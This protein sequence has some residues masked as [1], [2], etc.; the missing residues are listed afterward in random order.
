MLVSRKI[1][2]SKRLWTCLVFGALCSLLALDFLHLLPRSH[3][4]GLHGSTPGKPGKVI[5][6]ISHSGNRTQIA[7]FWVS[8]ES[9][10]REAKPQ[11]SGIK[12]NRFC[13]VDGQLH[14]QWFESLVF[15]ACNI[16]DMTYRPGEHEKPRADHINLDQQKF[17]CF[18]SSH[19]RMVSAARNLAPFLPYDNGTSGVVM[20]GGGKYNFP[21]LLSIRMLRHSGSNL[22]VELFIVSPDEYDKDICEKHLPALN[23]KCRLLS[24][25]FAATPDASEISQYQFKIFAILFSSFENVFF[26]DADAFVAFN[27]DEMLTSEPFTTSGLITWP[28]LWAESSSP[29][30][31]QMVGLPVPPIQRY[32]S[33]SGTI[34]YSKSKHA[35]SMILATYYNYY[36]PKYYYPLLSQGAHGQGDKETYLHAAIALGMDYWDVKT[37]LWEI[38]QWIEHRNFRRV[39]MGQHYPE[40][41]YSLSPADMKHNRRQTRPFV[42]HINNPWKVHPEKILGWKGPTWH[43]GKRIRILGTEQDM[44]DSFGYDIEEMMWNQVK[45]LACQLDI[46]CEKATT[47]YKDVFGKEEAFSVHKQ[48]IG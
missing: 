45:L 20:V 1:Q 22:P 6:S 39:G 33:D 21:A 15:G 12:V 35:A 10:L 46:G 26:L 14:P 17:D 29:L 8:L 43:K 7:D 19:E 30:F 31:F 48:A 4:Q 32:A 42:L 40:D 47:Y 41:D 16:D 24:D 34:V 36:G 3:F 2:C 5:P 9:Y 18:K 11:C 23:A 25:T 38:G 27:P 44:L 28:D 13:S 37:P